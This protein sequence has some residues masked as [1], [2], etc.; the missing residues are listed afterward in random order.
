MIIEVRTQEELD[1]A[2]VTASDTDLVACCGDGWFVAWDSSH[3]EARESSH[4]V[5]R[6]SSH[7][8]ASKYVAV[9]KMTPS[10]IVRGGVI[11]EPPPIDSPR[12]WLDYCGVPV[13]HGIVIL[14]KAVDEQY[15]ASHRLP[16]GELPDYSPGSKPAAPDFDPSARDCGCGLH[17]CASPSTALSY[18][19][20]PK[21]IAIPVRVSEMGKPDPNGDTNKIRFKR[22]AKPVYEVDIYGERVTP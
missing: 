4:V 16:N 8:V 5:A 9:H 19:R 13:T 20:G 15:H 21:F 17:A 22:A 6:G 2:L 1:K 3:V 10:A 11:I 14:Y 7:V 18:H 12:A